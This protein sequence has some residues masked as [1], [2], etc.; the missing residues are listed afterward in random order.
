MHDDITQ[1][2]PIYNSGR[3]E[4][5]FARRVILYAHRESQ[6]GTGPCITARMVTM[7]R[8]DSCY[9]CT[10]KP[11][12][13]SSV[14]VILSSSSPQAAICFWNLSPRVREFHCS[15]QGRWVNHGWPPSFPLVKFVICIHGKVE[16]EGLE[17]WTMLY[18]GVRDVTYSLKPIQLLSSFTE[19]R[20]KT[21]DLP[22]L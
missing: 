13:S 12:V 2:Q 7:G 20:L 8:R 21:G 17:G 19:D 15:S 10:Y 22:Y 6:R 5:W 4:Y 1:P 16:K 3:F 18:H 11:H 9:T 14:A